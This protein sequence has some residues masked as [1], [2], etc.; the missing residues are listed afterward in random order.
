MHTLGIDLAAADADTAGC[1]LGWAADGVRVVALEQPLTDDTICALAEGTA[2]VGIDAPLGWPAAFVAA[3]G[4]YAAGGAWP[5]GVDR[6][7]LR[8]RATDRDVHARLGI[9]PLSVSSERLAVVAFRAAAL[10]GR[11]QSGDPARDGSGRVAEVYPAAG[12]KT[13]GLPARGYKR[14]GQADVRGA[15]LAGLAERTRLVPGA[16]TERCIASADALDA[17][18]AAL[19][20]GA[21][22]REETWPIPRDRAARARAEGWIHLP[23]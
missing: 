20:A 6:L 11:L 1:L 12:L 19:L 14:P 5:E 21:I 16:W 7:D 3:V 4:G 18:V 8:M 13:W 9:W 15:I 23:R 2:K 17:L 10:L 22:V